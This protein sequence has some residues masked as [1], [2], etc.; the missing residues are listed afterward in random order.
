MHELLDL[1]KRFFQTGATLNYDFRKNA[2]K[3]LQLAIVRHHQDILDALFQ[4]L[5]KGETEAILTEVWMVEKELAYQMRHLKSWMRTKR[6]STDLT[7]IPG[8]SYSYFAPLGTS[9]ILSPWN[10]P[11]HLLFIP[12]IG[13][14]AAGNTAIVKPSLSSINTSKV[15]KTIIE[16]AFSLEYVTC[17]LA[18]HEETNRLL[19]ANFD[20][21]FFTGSPSI[22]KTVYE[23]AAKNLTKLT[24]ELGGKSPCI[25]DGTIKP[26]ITARR[27]IF[28][29]LINCGQTCIAPDYVICE[30]KALP[31]LLKYLEMAVKQAFVEDPLKTSDYPKMITK[32]HF[33]RMVS[34]LENQKLTFGGRFSPES[35]KIEPTVLVTDINNPFMQE[36]IFG[37]VLPIIPYDEESEID[38]IIAHSPNPL[39]LYVFS[40]NKVFI[41]KILRHHTFGGGCVNDTLSHIISD[42]LPF[43]G[44]KTSGL[45]NYHGLY[46]FKTFS[47]QVAIYHKHPTAELMIRYQ[48]YKPFIKKLIKKFFLKK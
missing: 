43:G 33:D 37:P 14:I 21:I 13:A 36:E 39:A 48:P 8:K 26:E 7:S 20:H 38:N 16:E 23:K 10:Y 42:N 28:G 29:K 11:F 3:K 41:D 45:G 35:L 24:L 32:R 25:V 44:V 19:E 46:S 40:K 9:F 12:L 17:V 30:R 22:G 5:N 1:Q 31:D 6:V 15:I 27:I 2:L 47:H 18:D 34:L 4:D